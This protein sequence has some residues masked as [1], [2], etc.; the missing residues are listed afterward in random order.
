MTPEYSIIVPVY[1]VEPYL[2][3]CVDSIL[4]QTYGGF[5]LFLVDDGSPDNCGAIC[6]EYAAKD[7][8]VTVLHQENKGVTA[9]RRSALDRA[10]ADYVCFVDADDYVS[11]DWLEQIESCAAANG[12]P[13]T[14]I[15]GSAAVRD[16]TPPRPL[17][18]QLLAPGYYDKARLERDIYPYMLYDRRR[19]HFF[20]QLIN[21]YLW[22]KV[23]RRQLLLDHFI[24]NERITLFEDA[25]MQYECLYN[26]NSFYCCPQIF[27]FYR[28]NDSSVLHRYNPTFIQ[29]LDLCQRYMEEHICRQMPEMQRQC[30][31]FFTQRLIS[32]CKL[33]FNFGHSLS[34]AARNIS[35]SLK[36]T[37]L[38]RRLHL[39]TDG[40]F[41]FLFLLLLKCR[42]WY[43]A[44]LMTKC[45]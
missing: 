4:A 41:R 40:V 6:D 23:Y 17:L 35:G 42:L 3:Q 12:R 45:I 14:L 18:S 16:D 11:P 44:L 30:D 36:E 15:F 28:Q 7:N 33:E 20:T 31:A 32:A 38:A 13:D 29:N 37:G 26:A 19:R 8:R 1:K 9:A 39:T 5:E 34:Q 24:R 2:R 25:A 22:E 27:Y 10:R 43:P 21:G